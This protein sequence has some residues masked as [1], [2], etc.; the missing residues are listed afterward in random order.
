MLRSERRKGLSRLD[1]V[2]TDLLD[3]TSTTQRE[4]PTLRTRPLRSRRLGDCELSA[5]TFLRPNVKRPAQKMANDLSKRLYKKNDDARSKYSS[6]S[7]PF[8]VKS[9]NRSSYRRV[10]MRGKPYLPAEPSFRKHIEYRS[11]H[12]DRN[13]VDWIRRLIR[14]FGKSLGIPARAA[15][16][17]APTP[18]QTSIRPTLLRWWRLLAIRATSTMAAPASSMAAGSR[19]W[20]MAIR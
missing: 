3:W 12:T 4:R 10:R 19:P 20:A 17:P 1:T 2:R 9:N 8:F 7:W 11:L 6:V 15:V 16:S 18:A 13:C 14:H 5:R